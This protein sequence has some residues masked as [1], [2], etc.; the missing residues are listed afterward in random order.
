MIA[1]AE[2]EKLSSEDKAAII[3]YSTNRF[4]NR[5]KMAYLALYTIVFTVVF[6]FIAALIDG[7]SGKTRILEMIRTNQTLITWL[8]GFLVSVVAAY[9]GVSAL[10]PSS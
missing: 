5:R 9:F 3:S 2:N 8:E 6:I 7:I 4:R 10:R 1:I